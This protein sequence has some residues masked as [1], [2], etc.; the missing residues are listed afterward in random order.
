[1]NGAEPAAGASNQSTAQGP[2]PADTSPA[3]VAEHLSSLLLSAD[4]AARRIVEE[5]QARARNQVAELEDRVRQIEAEGARLAGWRRHTEEMIQGLAAAVA[6]FT[7][8]VEGVPQRITEALTP[9]ASHVPLMVRQMD[10]LLSTL[11]TAPGAEAS[12]QATP[13]PP[14]PAQPPSDPTFVPGWDDLQTAP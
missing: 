13:P 9:L 3:S 5:A 1:M 10:Q 8:D 2:A 4:T 12:A 6:E 7:R 11:R 14:T